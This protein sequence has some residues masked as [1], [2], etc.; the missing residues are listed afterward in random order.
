MGLCNSSTEISEGG[1]E[2]EGE[3]E[4]G[5]AARFLERT[6]AQLCPHRRERE[7]E[8]ER[9]V[10]V[11]DHQGAS[12]HPRRRAANQAR[13]PART[14]GGGEPRQPIPGGCLVSFQP[15]TEPA[16]DAPAQR[17]SSALDAHPIPYNPP[18]HCHTLPLPL[19]PKCCQL[20]HSR[21]DKDFTLLRASH[22]VSERESN[23]RAS[24]W[25]TRRRVPVDA[26][27]RPWTQGRPRLDSS[28]EASSVVSE[29]SWPR[30]GRMLLTDCISFSAPSVRSFVRSFLRSFGLF[31]HQHRW[32]GSAEASQQ[33]TAHPTCSV[34]HITLLLLLFFGHFSYLS[35]R[36][37]LKDRFEIGP[38]TCRL[39]I[40]V[41][42]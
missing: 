17:P 38:V 23:D 12:T 33:V 27:G 20:C 3:R 24:D 18:P 1:R 30:R 41:T 4:R 7:R 29:L 32:L 34:H 26:V 22:R 6:R 5:I 10:V 36:H 19:N 16:G 13:P 25:R 39:C 21:R 28:S 37:H 9:E 14:R 31:S 8:R 2:R 11:D 35:P 42:S 40:P 15:P